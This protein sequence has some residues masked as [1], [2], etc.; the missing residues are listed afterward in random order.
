ML[1]VNHNIINLW[2]HKVKGYSAIWCQN[3]V[4]PFLR[5]QGGTWEHASELLKS[6]DYINHVLKFELL[7]LPYLEY[8]PDHSGLI[9]SP[10]L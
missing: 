10:I 2:A 1:P 4:N 7:G 9:S 6:Q 8:Y 5:V 3:P